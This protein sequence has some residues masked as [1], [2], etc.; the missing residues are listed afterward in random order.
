MMSE[1]PRHRIFPPAH[2]SVRFL[3]RSGCF[4]ISSSSRDSKGVLFLFFWNGS[5]F[6]IPSEPPV[7]SPSAFPSLAVE[8]AC[9]G[10]DGSPL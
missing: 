6:P 1:R 2:F 9:T 10:A 3:K 7:V 4:M 8:V 5:S